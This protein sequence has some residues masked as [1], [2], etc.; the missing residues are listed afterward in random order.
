[1]GTASTSEPGTNGAGAPFTAVLFDFDGTL[2]DSESPIFTI[3]QEIYLAHG[4][5]LT[6]AI[7]F[8][9]MGAIGFDAWGRLEQLAG[10]A[11]DRAAAEAHVARRKIELLAETRARPGVRSYLDDADALG[12]RRAIVSN[13]SRRRIARYAQQCDFGDG[14]SA[15]QAAEG[16]RSRA[17]P[18]PD[19]YLAA[20]AELGIRPDAALAFED[21]ST[22]VS[23]AKAAGLR[24]V[25]VPNPVTDRSALGDAD[26]V[27]DSFEQL[28]L[29]EVLATLA[30]GTPVRGPR[31]RGRTPGVLSRPP[32]GA[33]HRA[34]D[35]RGVA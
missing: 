20:L 33:E 14:W 21:C 34:H 5:R 35:R 32:D 10:V 31:I 28:T 16:D 24:C 9:F 13:S 22:G 3:Y 6:T 25:A 4:Q 27:L 15:V 2:W 11:V 29:R 18:R 23:A 19:L 7:W 26:L 8:T 1:M 30:L 12:L 17:K